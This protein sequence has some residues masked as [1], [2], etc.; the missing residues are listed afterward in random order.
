MASNCL[1]Y[2]LRLWRYGTRD[3]LVIRR[4]HWGWFP[5]F[6]VFFELQDGSIVKKEYVPD[7]PRPRWIPPL[8]F[9]G[10]EITTTY[11]KQETHA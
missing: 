3:H 8:L 11:L 2:A 5:H 7:A 9:K 1:L 4:S 6:A 10:R